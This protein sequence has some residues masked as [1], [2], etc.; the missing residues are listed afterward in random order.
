MS[1]KLTGK[2][3]ARFEAERNVWQEVLEGVQEIK[4]GG[5][6]RSVKQSASQ[7]AR[8]R[9][10]SGLSQAQ[11]A[12]AL[13]VSKRTLEQWEQGRR[14]PSGAAKTLL[15]IA[16]RHPKVLIEVAA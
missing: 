11:F 2:A 4:A 3:L 10:K 1:K 6:K 9:L 15:K 5:G 8:V 16:E 12:A 14:E 13:G 7:V